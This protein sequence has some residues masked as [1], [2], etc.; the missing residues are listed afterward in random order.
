MLKILKGN[1]AAVAKFG[2]SNGSGR[3]YGR[4]YGRGSR[5]YGRGYGYGRGC[6]YGEEKDNGMREVGSEH[7]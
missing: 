4:G 6:G 5:G 1:F 3:G 2:F 7:R